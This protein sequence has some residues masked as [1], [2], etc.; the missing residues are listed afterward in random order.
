MVMLRIESWS[1][2]RAWV[3]ESS[4][5]LNAF[6]YR[7]SLCTKLKGTELKRAA[8]QLRKHEIQEISITTADSANALIHTLES[9]GAKVAI[10]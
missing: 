4:W 6:E 9:L 1:A 8:R 5:D 7:L 10:K 2:D 3:S